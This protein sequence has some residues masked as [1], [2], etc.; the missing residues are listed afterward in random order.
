MYPKK[1]KA[2]A[3]I[4]AGLG[5]IVGGFF[6]LGPVFAFVRSQFDANLDIQPKSSIVVIETLCQAGGGPEV[7]PPAFE[8]KIAKG[9]SDDVVSI[10]WKNNLDGSWQTTVAGEAGWSSYRGIGLIHQIRGWT[11]LPVR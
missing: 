3:Q 8:C 7:N 9:Q 1:L 11:I 10:E 6:L 4:P 2:Y 5:V